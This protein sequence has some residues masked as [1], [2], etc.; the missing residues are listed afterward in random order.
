MQD[1]SNPDDLCII[2]YQACKFASPVLD[3]FYN[4][5]GSTESEFR[6]KEYQNLLQHYHKSLSKAIRRLGSDPELL[7][8]YKDLENE[9]LRFGKY[10]FLT[11]PMQ[12]QM[13]VAKSQE[14]ANLDEFCEGIV[15]EGKI[16]FVTNLEISSD[17]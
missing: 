11:G 3:L 17:G 8:T 14:I 5:F 16:D 13:H 7:F 6:Q 2:D 12:I 1:V 15:K 9:L 10:P 4:I